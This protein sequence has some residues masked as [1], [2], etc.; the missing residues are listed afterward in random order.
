M[1]IGRKGAFRRENFCGLIDIDCI[2]GYGMPKTSWRKLSRV[3]VK[4]Q[5]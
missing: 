5:N 1:W 2:D 3:A 4:L